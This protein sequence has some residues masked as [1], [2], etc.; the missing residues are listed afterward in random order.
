MEAQPEKGSPV[1][2]KERGA[3]FAGMTL[4]S[5]WIALLGTSLLWMVVG[6]CKYYGMELKGGDW[7]QAAASLTGVG[8]AIFIANS[9]LRRD[10]S[11]EKNKKKVALA[12]LVKMAE[13]AGVEV[14]Q[15]YL[16]ASPNNRSP[17]HLERVRSME[18]SFMAVDILN[19]PDAKM[20]EHVLQIRSM[21]EYSAQQMELA[22]NLID[23]KAAHSAWESLV[24]AR[25]LINAAS[26]NLRRLAE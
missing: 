22:H 10:A 1:K 23:T 19:L 17:M 8:A 20:V 6:I 7:V 5:V 15:L 3:L 24:A 26:L 21:L 16:N 14:N 18:R 13:V 9:Q 4:L 12:A 25:I 2:L 11:T